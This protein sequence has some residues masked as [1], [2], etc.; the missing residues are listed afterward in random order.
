MEWHIERFLLCQIFESVSDDP[1]DFLKVFQADLLEKE[2]LLFASQIGCSFTSLAILMDWIWD[3]RL[4]GKTSLSFSR[5]YWLCDMKSDTLIFL[6]L[7]PWLVTLASAPLYVQLS[8]QKGMLSL[9]T[10]HNI[11]F[12]YSFLISINL[13]QEWEWE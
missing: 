9:P 6:D 11:Y 1:F 2:P 13:L 3:T 4:D 10:F 5:F 7:L 8:H 12:S